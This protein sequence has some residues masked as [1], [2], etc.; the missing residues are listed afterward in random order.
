MEAKRQG[1]P[2]VMLKSFLV[3]FP[4]Q[5]ST[6]R[7]LPSACCLV[8]SM[9]YQVNLTSSENTC[10]VSPGSCRS[11]WDI[12]VPTLTGSWRSISMNWAS[13]G[14]SQ[15]YPKVFHV[16]VY[17]NEEWMQTKS[18]SK[19]GCSSKSTSTK[20]VRIGKE[21]RHDLENCFLMSPKMNVYDT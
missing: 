6:L 3:R 21:S 16:T 17:L 18:L 14:S 4:G 11:L 9:H 19:N 12:A 10:V 7:N 15:E 13:M 8:N 1:R 5:A 20:E 2:G